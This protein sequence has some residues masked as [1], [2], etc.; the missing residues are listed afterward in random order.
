MVLIIININFY[1]IS[2]EEFVME[3]SKMIVMGFF[4]LEWIDFCLI[5]N[6]INFDGD[7]N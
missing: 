6:L 7:L 4:G 5:W 3:K 2:F 1:L